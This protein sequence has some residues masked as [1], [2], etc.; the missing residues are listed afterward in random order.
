[1]SIL[2]FWFGTYVVYKLVM[3]Y[4]WLKERKGGSR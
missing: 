2:A 3:G 1:M 4:F